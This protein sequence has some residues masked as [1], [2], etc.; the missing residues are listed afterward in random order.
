IA[1][2]ASAQQPAGVGLRLII[3]KTVEEPAGFQSRLQARDA[4]EEFA[5]KYSSD[6]AASAGGYLGIARIE[7]LRKEFQVVL[8]GLRPGQVSPI[9]KV[10][11]GHAQLQVV[12]EAELHDYAGRALG[13]QGNWTKRLLSFEKRCASTPTTTRPTSIWASRWVIWRN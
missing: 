5:K 3:V 12:P 8:A 4:F 1:V 11:E 9:V 2:S 7:D 6:S 10:N 13:R